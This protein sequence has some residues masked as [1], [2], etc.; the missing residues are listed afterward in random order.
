MLGGPGNMQISD[1]P[2]QAG[3]RSYRAIETLNCEAHSSGTS[4][5]SHAYKQVKREPF[6]GHI[7]ELQFGSLQILRDRV[8]NPIDYHGAPVEGTVGFFV[9]L[10]SQGNAYC[11]GRPLGTNTILKF[12]NNYSHRTFCTGPM[13]SLGITV[14]LETFGAYAKHETGGGIDRERLKDGFRVSDPDIV[15]NFI[16]TALGIIDCAALD[17]SIAEDAHWRNYTIE[18]IHSLLLGVVKAGIS[19]PLRLPDPTTRAYVVD[20]AVRFMEA[21]VTET[22]P[23]S[24]ICEAVRVSPRTLRYSFEQIVGVSPMQYMFSL[25]LHAVRRV[26]L[27]GEANKSIHRVAEHY[28]FEHLSRFAQ[29]YR[30]AFGELPSETTAASGKYLP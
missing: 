4:G 19:A 8:N 17:P 3:N 28:G 18:K 15:H 30:E 21:H 26:L 11:R 7:S 25:R 14:N 9:C 13:D 1:S 16:E 12:P 27:N 24:R 29:Y 10:P 2:H 22:L 5:W 20:K 6:L 23:M